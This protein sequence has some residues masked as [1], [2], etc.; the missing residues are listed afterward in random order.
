MNILCKR[1]I[2]TRFYIV[3]AFAIMIT[4]TTAH[5]SYQS[6]PLGKQM[7]ANSVLGSYY[8]EFIKHYGKRYGSSEQAFRSFCRLLR[9]SDLLTDELI[10]S[11]IMIDRVNDILAQLENA[12]FTT[13]STDEIHRNLLALDYALEM[14]EADLSSNHIQEFRREVLA[15]VPPLA[16]T[17]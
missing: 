17:G 9:E 1:Y 3:I 7:I 6:S 8:S 4:G 5:A 2:V 15:R 10:E 12:S 13:S 14:V 11:G 16:Y